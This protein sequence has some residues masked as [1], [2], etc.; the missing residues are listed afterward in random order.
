MVIVEW[1]VMELPRVLKKYE[2]R[3]HVDEQSQCWVWTGPTNNGYGV[4]SRRMIINGQRVGP[5]IHRIFYAQLHGPIPEGLCLDHLCENKLCVNPDHLESVTREENT[6]R[7]YRKRGFTFEFCKHGHPYLGNRI[8]RGGR[9][10]GTECK[11]CRRIAEH[12]RRR[13]RRAVYSIM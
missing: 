7:W 8:R 6:A 4:I 1:A 10:K 2:T 13:R 9:H 5:R 3:I 12:Q 11:R